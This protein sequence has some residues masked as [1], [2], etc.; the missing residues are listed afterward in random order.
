LT[1]AAR[2]DGTAI[3]REVR[4]ESRG[5]PPGSPRPAMCPASP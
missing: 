3:A 1:T 5:A 2:I 4:A